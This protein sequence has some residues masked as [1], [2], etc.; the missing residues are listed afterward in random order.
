M[1]IL[2][3]ARVPGQAVF[4]NISLVR[5][6]AGFMNNRQEYKTWCEQYGLLATEM[7]T[8]RAPVKAC[9][10]R[11]SIRH[12]SFLGKPNLHMW[13]ILGLTSL[14]CRS[15]GKSRGVSVTDGL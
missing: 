10:G 4:D 2:A 11:V 1:V 8:Q 12:G 3:I 5:I 9:K 6:G 13:K 14:W 7:V 15:V